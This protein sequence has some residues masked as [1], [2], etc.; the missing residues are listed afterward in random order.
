MLLA[1][2]EPLRALALELVTLLL[3]RARAARLRGLGAFLR[4][5]GGAASLRRNAGCFVCGAGG[6]ARRFGGCEEGRWDWGD[7]G[8]GGDDDGLGGEGRDGMMVELVEGLWLWRRG[9]E[10]RCRGL[11]MRFVQ[12][13]WH[14]R[15]EG[16][17]E[18]ERAWWAVVC[19]RRSG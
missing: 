11:E 13:H 1:Q 6:G 19:D 5:R 3:L 16:K 10:A 12:I 14:L 17:H 7:G 8:D 4:C 15:E 2:A 18:A 9:W